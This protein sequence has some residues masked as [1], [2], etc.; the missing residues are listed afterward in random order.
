LPAG[1]EMCQLPKL[2]QERQDKIR[3]TTAAKAVPYETDKGYE[4]PDRIV[5]GVTTK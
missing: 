1:W 3:D 5:V 2:P 4:F